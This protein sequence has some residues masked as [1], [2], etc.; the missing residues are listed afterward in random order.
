MS[1]SWHFPASW[2]LTASA[3]GLASHW[4]PSLL[5]GIGCKAC[6]CSRRG[7]WR[8]RGCSV[9]RAAEEGP[10]PSACWGSERVGGKDV[11]ASGKAAAPRPPGPWQQ[12]TATGGPGGISLVLP[13]GRPSSPLGAG[14]GSS[15]YHWG[16][17]WIKRDEEREKVGLFPFSYSWDGRE[18]AEPDWMSALW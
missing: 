4:A 12:M 13:W 11:P 7:C 8:P 17:L 5:P 3:A 10:Q 1:P 18:R 14:N 2:G 6:G 15:D 9:W 16:L